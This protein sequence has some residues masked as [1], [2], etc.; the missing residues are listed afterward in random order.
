MKKPLIFKVRKVLRYIELYGIGRTLMKVKGQYH[1]AS[2]EGF[3]GDVWENPDCQ[4]PDAEGR[5]VGFIGCGAFTFGQLAYYV[6]QVDRNCFRAGMDVSAA[7]ARSL[8]SHF[9]GA[10]ATTDAE[11]IIQNP[12]ID[13]IYIASNHAT[14]AEYAIQALDA[15]KDV[16]IEKPHVVTEDQ[17]TRLMAAIKRNSDQKVYL[18]FNRPR[19]TLFARLRHEL[20]KERGPSMI[21]WFVAGHA[22]DDDHWYFKES[23]GGRLL[24]NLCHWSDLTLEMVGLENAFPLRVIPA[25]VPGARSD[26]VTSIEFADGSLASITFSAK[27]HTFEGVREV[28]NVHKG[29]LLAEVKDFKSVSLVRGAM[30]KRISS[31]F[32]DHGHKANALN[33]F[34]GTR[35][36]DPSRAVDPQYLWASAKLFLAIKQAHD[37]GKPVTIE[38]WTCNRM[39]PV[40]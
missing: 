23:E 1:M 10:F 38:E 25:A 3:Q 7:R 13:L 21:N 30:R 20:E 32:R 29:D 19:S 35:Q 24:G 40:N 34:K 27:G 39:E 9:K 31:R 6:M 15:G 17:L 14:H 2:S 28:L 16:H 36:N 5:S 4:N 33:S 26:F 11:K 12:K 18:G 22:I 8:V 37:Y